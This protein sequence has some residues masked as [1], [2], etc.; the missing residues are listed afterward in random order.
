MFSRQIPHHILTW[1]TVKMKVSL[2]GVCASCPYI[3]ILKLIY[4]FLWS[5]PYICCKT[6]AAVCVS[7]WWNAWWSDVTSK[8]NIPDYLTDHIIQSYCKKLCE[9][10]TVHYK[11]LEPWCK[12]QHYMKYITLFCSLWKL[13]VCVIL[14]TN[15]VDS[16]LYGL[17]IVICE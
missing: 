13:S 8:G 14:S 11:S 3:F 6:W 16:N 10:A 12:L 2:S 5:T 4:C 15:A 1:M 7:K 17:L 9:T